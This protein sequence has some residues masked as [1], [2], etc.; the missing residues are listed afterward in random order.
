MT[1]VAELEKTVADVKAYAEKIDEALGKTNE[2]LEKLEGRIDTMEK[3]NE[4]LAG[5]AGED[6]IE[7]KSE[8]TALRR[9]VDTLKG[10][11]AKAKKSGG[12]SVEGRVAVLEQMAGIGKTP[13][14]PEEAAGGVAYGREGDRVMAYRPENFKNI[15]ESVVGF[16]DTEE[17]ALADLESNE[18]K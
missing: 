12:S 13:E 1:T 8:A 4:Q 16:G 17:E 11:A 3:G 15:A 6:L 9:D 14:E 10:G 18:E 5:K 7:L 2:R